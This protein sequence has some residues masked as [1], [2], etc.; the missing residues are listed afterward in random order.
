MVRNLI[1]KTGTTSGADRARH[2]NP[3]WKFQ[4]LEQLVE[5]G[6]SHGT[7]MIFQIVSIKSNQSETNTRISQRNRGGSGGRAHDSGTVRYKRS[8]TLMCLLSD[9]KANIA[10]MFQGMGNN[11]N[12][13]LCDLS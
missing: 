5:N 1:A 4:S 8:V 3:N 7:V 10:M 9:S 2:I 6:G 13:F 11:E 12:L